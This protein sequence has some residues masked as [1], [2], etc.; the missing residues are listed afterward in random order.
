MDGFSLLALSVLCLRGAQGAQVPK[1][2][3][4]GCVEVGLALT[5]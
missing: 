1:V 5:D 4:V 3:E 2:R